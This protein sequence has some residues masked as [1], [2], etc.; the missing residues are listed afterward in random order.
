MVWQLAGFHILQASNDNLGDELSETQLADHSVMKV[1][2]TQVLIHFVVIQCFLH[3][4]PVAIVEFSQFHY[5][6]SPSS[7]LVSLGGSP[8]SM[9]N[10]TIF[11][12][13]EDILLLKQ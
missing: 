11:G 3:N 2:L 7:L 12:V 1:W 10:F 13:I 6:L 8:R 5:L 4:L 9:E